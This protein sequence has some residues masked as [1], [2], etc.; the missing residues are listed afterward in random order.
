[1]GGRETI[2]K[3]PQMTPNLNP[4]QGDGVIGTWKMLPLTK[5]KYIHLHGVTQGGG[6]ERRGRVRKLARKGKKRKG[7]EEEKRGEKGKKKE[8]EKRKQP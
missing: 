5:K 1:M 8:G 3:Q 2:K 4:N 6:G 7:R